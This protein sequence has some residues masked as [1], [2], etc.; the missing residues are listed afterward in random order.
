MSHADEVVAAVHGELTLDYPAIPPCV[1]VE[2]EPVGDFG[3]AHYLGLTPG[4]CA[5]LTFDAGYEPL[6][7]TIAHELGHAMHQYCGGSP[8]WMS[9]DDP[10]LSRFWPVR[11]PNGPSLGDV[12]RLAIRTEQEQGFGA[13]YGYYVGEIFA[14]TFSRVAGWGWSGLTANFDTPFLPP[15][16]RI[17]GEVVEQPAPIRDACAAFFRQLRPLGAIPP[18]EEVDEMDRDTFNRWFL[19]ETRRLITP[20]IVAV[21]DVV[22]DHEHDVATR[23]SGPRVTLGNEPE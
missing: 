7:W 4:G 20:T 8:F 22:N 16:L 1:Q 11:F 15:P 2:D 10:V 13:A 23:T 3:I 21:K 9:E 6:R 18:K 14:D 12:I 19:E 17:D 5:H